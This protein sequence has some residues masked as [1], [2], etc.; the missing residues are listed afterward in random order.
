MKDKSLKSTNKCVA[1]RSSRLEGIRLYRPFPTKTLK[2]KIATLLLRHFPLL[3]RSIPLKKMKKYVDFPFHGPILRCLD[4]GLGQLGKMPSNKV[5]E[6][7]YASSYWSERKP[8]LDLHQYLQSNRARSQ[9]EFIQ[10]SFEGRK[11]SSI[12][13]IGAG[14]ATSSLLLRKKLEAT[15]IVQLSVVEPGSVWSDYYKALSIECLGSYFPMAIPRKFSHIHAS[16]WLEHTTDPQKA[17][18]GM[19]DCLEKNG[20]VFLE[21]PFA[22]DSYWD[23]AFADAPH[24]LFFN[25]DSLNALFAR[26]GFQMLKACR[27]GISLASW[28][29]GGWP[30]RE[31]FGRENKMGFWIRALYRKAEED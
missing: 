12:L 16:H 7:F 23:R 28:E 26:E 17:V 11:I 21:V 15:N 6:S 10:E 20:T 31:E 19:R 3:Y 13:E 8:S 25:V 27:V 4:C 5:L 29:V 30:N 2:K 24:T 1:C 18:S 22:D 14:A 9:V